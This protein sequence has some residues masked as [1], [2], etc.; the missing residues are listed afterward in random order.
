MTGRTSAHSPHRIIG[1]SPVEEIRLVAR[2]TRPAGFRFTAASLPGHLIQLVVAG[3]VSQSSNGRRCELAAGDAMWYHGDEEVVGEVVE[4]PWTVLSVNFTAPELPPPP[5]D[6]RVFSPAPPRLRQ[7]FTALQAR[8]E[9]RACTA[10]VLG[11]HAELAALLAALMDQRPSLPGGTGDGDGRWWRVERRIRDHLPG[12]VC[13]G[14]AASWAG[15]SVATL[16]R[17]CRQATGLPTARRMRELRLSH[18]R[19]LV[20]YSSL[21]IG[22]IARSL[23]FPR[24]HE[25]SRAYHRRFGCPPSQDRMQAAGQPPEGGRPPA[26]PHR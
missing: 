24:V 21:A 11:A 3:R 14:E 23:G 25:F 17:L 5:E 8:W 13:I 18:A 4:A 22:S 2:F 26:A 15:T 19:G 12:I 6:A 10:A 7:R 20:L 9:D 16:N 1:P